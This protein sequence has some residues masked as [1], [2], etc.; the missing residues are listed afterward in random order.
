MATSTNKST[1]AETLAATVRAT[2]QAVRP[3]VATA[4][5]YRRPDSKLESDPGPCGKCAACLAR[6]AFYDADDTPKDPF[7]ALSGL[8]AL[9]GQHKLLIKDLH[10][11]LIRERFGGTPLTHKQYID[12]RKRVLS[13]D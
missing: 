6:N 5:C 1:D 12:L 3:I 4:R 8:V 9:V 7:A 11:A 10:S 13:Y 2:I